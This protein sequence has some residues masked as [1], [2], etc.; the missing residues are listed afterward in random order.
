MDAACLYV[1]IP[2]VDIPV[3]A[4][5]YRR[6]GAIPVISHWGGIIMWKT[7]IF[8][9][10][11][12]LTASGV[13]AQGN[14]AN[15]APTPQ[16][17]ESTINR[18]PSITNS[19]DC[20]DLPWPATDEWTQPLRS[21]LIG[22]RNRK[23]FAAA[24]SARV[25]WDESISQADRPLPPWIGWTSECHGYADLYVYIRK[26]V[27]GLV[28]VVLVLAYGSN[29][30]IPVFW[31]KTATVQDM[32]IDV[33]LA[34]SQERVNAAERIQKLHNQDLKRDFA[35]GA[36]VYFTCVGVEET[37]ISEP[38]KSGVWSKVPCSTVLTSLGKATKNG[39]LKVQ[40]EQGIVAYV[41]TSVISSVKP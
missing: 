20:L 34:V 10:A 25:Y 16:Q 21:G 30:G 36:Q 11:I 1:Y 3:V 32:W 28:P 18:N 26:E 40:T 9:A 19:R 6:D 35:A 17:L 12:P 4:V 23:A 33:R 39:Y 22:V 15:E 31:D 37:I 41:S 24:H 5:Y 13:I 38:S 27:D 2:V 29:T 8:L 7:C 14:N